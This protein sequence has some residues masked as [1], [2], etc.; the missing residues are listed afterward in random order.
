MGLLYLTKEEMDTLWNDLA[1]AK[2][3]FEEH[4]NKERM[5]KAAQLFAL[6]TY[7]DKVGIEIKKDGLTEE[8]MKDLQELPA[9]GF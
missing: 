6:I 3:A 8:G 4:G 7:A 2:L 5:E 9:W 1:A